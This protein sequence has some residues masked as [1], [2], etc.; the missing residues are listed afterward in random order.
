MPTI[1]LPQLV[2]NTIS[3]YKGSIEQ[4][5]ETL[6]QTYTKA[7]ISKLVGGLSSPSKMPCHSYSLAAS[8]CNVGSKLKNIPNSVCYSC[9]AA[10]NAAWLKQ[11]KHSGMY[12]FAN[13]KNAMERR[14]QSLF[15][16]TWVPAMVY[17][18]RKTGNAY[19]RWHDSGDLQSA[20]HLTNIAKVALATPEV[21]HWLPTREYKLVR[22]W[23]AVNAVPDNL[24]IRVSAPMVD[25][26]LNNFPTSSL[27]LENKTPQDLN[28]PVTAT[29]CKAYLSDNKCNAC[30]ACWSKSTTHVW[31]H[32]H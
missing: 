9:Y 20:E 14:Y 29:E 27:V 31:Y 26:V 1:S 10:D 24:V 12:Q 13:V 2:V 18:I 32:K 25:T 5:I 11:G 22:D 3:E 6:T 28:L 30:R 8:R 21:K 7:E 17:L 23:M 16:S 15:T 4:D 19:F